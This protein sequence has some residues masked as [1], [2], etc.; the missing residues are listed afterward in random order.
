MANHVSAAKR[1][2]QSE[3]RR[4]NNRTRKGAMRTAIKA[5][6][7]AVEADDKKAAGKALEEATTLI[8]RAGRKG[9]IHSNQASRRVSRLTAK[10]K[11][12]SA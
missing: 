7:V 9:L 6:L 1:A 8:D 12:L 10:V 5:V 2:R 11:G 3:K 4:L